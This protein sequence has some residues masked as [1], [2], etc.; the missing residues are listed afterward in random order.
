M[1]YCPATDYTDM[2]TSKQNLLSTQMEEANDRS[3]QWQAIITDRLG[4]GTI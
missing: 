1:R 2:L 4:G 3:Q